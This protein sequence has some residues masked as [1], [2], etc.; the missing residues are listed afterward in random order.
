MAEVTSTSGKPDWWMDV[1]LSTRAS[2][3]RLVSVA[4][5]LISAGPYTMR[6]NREP[7]ECRKWGGR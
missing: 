6:I 5:A 3:I 7:D 2:T 4:M 1:L